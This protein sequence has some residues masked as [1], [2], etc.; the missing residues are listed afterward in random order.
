M[1]IQPLAWMRAIRDAKPTP[2]SLLV[3]LCL[4]LR[5]RSDG[6]GFASTRQ[7][8][9]DASVGTRTVER[10][11]RWARESSYL[12]R[13]RRGH[14]LGDGRVVASEWQL[15]APFSIRQDRRL[16]NLNPPNPNLNP[17]N[18]AP[19]PDTGTTT[20]VFTQRSSPSTRQARERELLLEAG[21]AD[22]E[23]I[24]DEIAGWHTELYGNSCPRTHA[25]SIRAMFNGKPRSYIRAAMTNDHEKYR[26]RPGPPRFVNGEFVT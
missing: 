13:A 11:T 20:E 19:Q 18:G 16:G 22:D 6:T 23:K 17:P 5:M 26:F 9:D 8:A 2:S 10:A 25:A 15:S 12:I 14:R 1:G 7:L 4:G 3:L 24:I 21:A